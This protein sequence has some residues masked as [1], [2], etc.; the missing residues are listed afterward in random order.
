MHFHLILL[1]VTNEAV[2]ITKDYFYILNYILHF[3]LHFTFAAHTDRDKDD[4]DTTSSPAEWILELETNL[5]E[6]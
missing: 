1:G 3:T 2:N 6:D 4:T 5:H